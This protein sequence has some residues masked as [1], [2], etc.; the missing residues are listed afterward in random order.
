MKKEIF[1]NT[2]Q[3]IQ[4]EFCSKNHFDYSLL[5]GD[6]GKV[7]FLYIASKYNLCEKSVADDCLNLILSS[8]KHRPIISSYCNGL[9]GLCVGLNFLEEKHFIEGVSNSIDVYDHY[10]KGQLRKSIKHNL[11]FLHGAIGIGFFFILRAQCND[12]AYQQVKFILQFLDENS[13]KTKDGCIYWKYP[14]RFGVNEEN[15]SLS[16]GICSTALFIS[17]A[18]R[19]LNSHDRTLSLKLLEGIGRYL[20]SNLKDPDEL[21]SFTPMFPNNARSRL[22]WCY[23]DIGTSIAL[24]AIGEITQNPILSQASFQIASYT[25]THRRNLKFNFVNDAC[26]YHGASGIA[27]FFKNCLTYYQDVSFK[28]AYMWWK[29]IT[30]EM[31][32]Y[33]NGKF[34]FGNFRYDDSRIHECLNLLEGDA[35]ATLMLMDEDELIDNILLSILR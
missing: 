34:M 31:Y 17:R 23:G 10:L 30:L 35:G 8:I 14:N 15:L 27:H 4:N 22:G 26:L 6:F 7:L 20:M 16:H 25:A 29:N 21:G 1:R 13:Y 18:Y 32:K 33:V 11:D 5:G 2:T 3:C 19:V 28:E 24:R 9:A 12:D